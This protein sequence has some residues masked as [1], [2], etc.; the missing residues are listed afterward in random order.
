MT[1]LPGNVTLEWIGGLLLS[2]RED[3]RELRELRTAGPTFNAVSGQEFMALFQA[4][5]SLR[6]DYDKLRERVDA[7]ERKGARP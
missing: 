5:R 2:M 7:L 4:H 1:D 6:D 3:I